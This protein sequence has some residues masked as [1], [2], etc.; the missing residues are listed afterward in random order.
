MNRRN[1][2]STGRSVSTGEEARVPSP[3][4]TPSEVKERKRWKSVIP[5]GG[6]QLGEVRASIG[7][8][9]VPELGEDGPYKSL[10][11]QRRGIQKEGCPRRLAAIP[12]NR[13]LASASS[14]TG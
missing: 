14:I 8:E 4:L 10:F 1:A 9:R 12:Y 3:E 6:G 5:M 2:D 11:E 7:K 13:R